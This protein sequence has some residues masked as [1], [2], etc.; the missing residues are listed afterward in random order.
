[1]NCLCTTRWSSRFR[2]QPVQLDRMATPKLSL[3]RGQAVAAAGLKYVSGRNQGRPCVAL[4][5]MLLTALFVPG[6]GRDGRPPLGR[7]QGVVTLDSEPLAGALVVFEPVEPARPSRGVTDAAGR[8]TL[9]YLRDIEGAV[10]GA[11]E[12]K[13]TTAGEELPHERVPARYNQSTT[14][15]AEVDRGRNERNFELTSR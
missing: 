3:V 14:L 9:T 8:Y 5:L 15:T 10:I 11:H 6:C 7:V 4:A 2:V 13:I 1:M 12:V